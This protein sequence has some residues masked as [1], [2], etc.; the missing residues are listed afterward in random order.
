LKLPESKKVNKAGFNLD[1]GNQLATE[2]INVRKLEGFVTQKDMRDLA[3]PASRNFLTRMLYTDTDTVCNEANFLLAEIA[4]LFDQSESVLTA[5]QS[6]AASFMTPL[7][8]TLFYLRRAFGID[9]N[10]SITR[11]SFLQWLHYRTSRNRLEHKIQKTRHEVQHIRERMETRDKSM[12]QDNHNVVLLRFFMLEQLPSFER[13]AM[14]YQNFMQSYITP[15]YVHPFLW[16][17]GWLLLVG[18]LIFFIVWVLLWCLTSRG[19]TFTAW[20]IT[21]GLIILEEIFVIQVLQVYLMN[22][23]I[24]KTIIP[25][26]EMIAEVLKV[27]S[28]DIQYQENIN[29]TLNNFR[30]VQYLSPS[31]RVARKKAYCGLQAGKVLRYVNDLHV[32]NCRHP[33]RSKELDL[34]SVCVLSLP[35]LLVRAFGDVI[36]EIMFRQL[37]PAIICIMILLGVYMLIWSP[38]WFAVITGAMIVIVILHRIWLSAKNH[39]HLKLTKKFLGNYQNN[40]GSSQG[41]VLRV[42]SNRFILFPVRF[43]FQLVVYGYKRLNEARLNRQLYDKKHEIQWRAINVPPVF[44]TSTVSADREQLQSFIKTHDEIMQTNRSFHISTL[45]K[46]IDVNEC[47]EEDMKETNTSGR[48]YVSLVGHE[49]IKSLIYNPLTTKIPHKFTLWNSSSV[50]STDSLTSMRRNYKANLLNNVTLSPK[51][52]VH[53]NSLNHTWNDDRVDGRYAFTH[54]KSRDLHEAVIRGILVVLLEQIKLNKLSFNDLD[55]LEINLAAVVTS[56]QLNDANKLYSCGEH[57]WNDEEDGDDLSIETDENQLFNYSKSRFDSVLLHQEQCEAMLVRILELYAPTLIHESDLDKF[58]NDNYFGKSREETYF[59]DIDIVVAMHADRW[60]SLN[61]LLNEEEMT[62][63]WQEFNAWLLEQKVWPAKL[64]LYS[65]LHWCLPLLISVEIHIKRKFTEFINRKLQ[66]LQVM[67]N[68]QLND[69]D[70]HWKSNVKK[71][72][73]KTNQVYFFQDY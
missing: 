24:L 41:K 25:R 36:G 68:K 54:E 70:D 43:L 73:N 17:G 53:K 23:A 5:V 33:Q 9:A 46:E 56:E 20:L 45:S 31:C 57:F 30:A 1:Q 47:I 6:S 49:E 44:V 61:S 12:A 13:Y 71:I 18:L 2:N 65:F 39:I 10:G 42:R 63:I 37:V 32:Y 8:S 59:A 21:S 52:I 62:D 4:T 58:Y 26:L 67:K 3:E 19:Y 69:Y 50:V 15:K 34:F 60:L 55:E 72:K 48:G 29:E 7:K 66:K 64:S 51:H 35:S 28:M 16:A 22:I 14:T 38:I 27:L 11:F 40:Y